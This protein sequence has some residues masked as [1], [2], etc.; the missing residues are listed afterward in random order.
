MCN[1]CAFFS[2]RSRSPAY[3]KSSTG[4]GWQV[5]AGAYHLPSSFIPTCTGIADTAMADVPHEVYAFQAAL[6]NRLRDSPNA[7]CDKDRAVRNHS[8]IE[9]TTTAISGKVAAR[10]SESGES[11]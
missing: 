2:R 6:R 10:I 9:P 7:I 8:L 5:R 1:V 11:E 3:L 4:I